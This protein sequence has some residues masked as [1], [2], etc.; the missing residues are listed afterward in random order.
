M[1][2]LDAFQEHRSMKIVDVLR[3]MLVMEILKSLIF[4]AS[5]SSLYSGPASR[6][7]VSFH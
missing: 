2:A 6:R 3:S 5:M 7:S 4:V 1:L